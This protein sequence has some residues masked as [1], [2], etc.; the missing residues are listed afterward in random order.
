MTCCKKQT[1]KMEKKEGGKNISFSKTDADLMAERFSVFSE[2]SDTTIQK[3]NQFSEGSDTTILKT[4]QWNQWI[5]LVVKM[6][7]CCLVLQH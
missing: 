3:T 7:C 6:G 5:C 4:Y 1:W 2:D